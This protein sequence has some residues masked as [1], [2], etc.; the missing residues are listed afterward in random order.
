M[1]NWIHTFAYVCIY[2]VNTFLSMPTCVHP[3]MTVSYFFYCELYI[4]HVN[5]AVATALPPLEMKNETHFQLDE[6]LSR[7]TT[8]HIRSFSLLSVWNSRRERKW[9]RDS[10]FLF[11]CQVSSLLTSKRQTWYYSWWNCH[12]KTWNREYVL[13]FI[14]T[15]CDEK[16]LDTSPISDLK[17]MILNNLTSVLYF[18]Y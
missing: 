14:H 2:I 6:W 3:Y 11:C 12:K 18:S 5:L 15:I 16:C 1:C 8:F 4:K 9:V 17:L 13:Y 7:E 10:T